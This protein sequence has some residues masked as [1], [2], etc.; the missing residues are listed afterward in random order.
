MIRPKDCSRGKTNN[1]SERKNCSGVR[2]STHSAMCHLQKNRHSIGIDDSLQHTCTKKYQDSNKVDLRQVKSDSQIKTT[3]LSLQSTLDPSA[4][5]SGTSIHAAPSVSQN[6]STEMILNSTKMPP[7]IQTKTASVVEGNVPATR[8]K[9]CM[10][11][12]KSMKMD[13][14]EKRN[15][16]S[17]IHRGESKLK[18]QSEDGFFKSFDVP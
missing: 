12:S 3:N 2:S 14:Y 10:T 11:R 1:S 15:N 5:T 17:N 7:H 13:K 16:A 8:S 4:M 18:K 6:L 9:V